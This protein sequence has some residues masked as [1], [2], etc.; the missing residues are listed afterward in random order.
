[1]EI[2]PNVTLSC[3]TWRVH[4]IDYF[5]IRYLLFSLSRASKKCSGMIRIFEFT[6]VFLAISECVCETHRDGAEVHAWF[7]RS[8]CVVLNSDARSCQV[9]RSSLEA[10]DAPTR[11]IA[12]QLLA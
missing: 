9:T 3:T 2:H 11:W 6:S 1:M 10:N 7:E 4:A 12:C 5:Y 8:S